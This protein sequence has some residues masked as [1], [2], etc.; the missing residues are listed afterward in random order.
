MI[1]INIYIAIFNYYKKNDRYRLTEK[2]F[3]HYRNIQSS[4]KDS[5]RFT[6]TIQG[7]EGG[8]S[9]ELALKYFD[10]S[11][12]IEYN[13]NGIMANHKDFLKMFND[14]VNTGFKIGTLCNTP[15]ISFW[16]GSNDYISGNF[17]EQVLNHYKRDT[18]QIYGIDKHTNGKN[19]TCLFN[20]TKNKI[21][22]LD[23]NNRNIFW[24]TG[25]EKHSDRSKYKYIGGIIG[26]N[27][28]CYSMYPDIIDKWGFDEGVNE[29]Y[30]LDKNG[31]DALNTQNVIF[32]NP[33][34]NESNDITSYNNLIDMNKESKIDISKLNFE[35][36][37]RMQ[38]EYDNF[39]RL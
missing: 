8:F 19:I 28:K 24:W 12:Y 16:A 34:V 18:P 21:N 37:D 20:Y 2:I 4:F 14:K 15:D 25:N 26:I 39:I 5:I 22:I 1:H 27:K 38:N 3:K 11:C 36:R 6:F 17:F 31:I 7:S 30:I 10:D 35:M 29:K 32:L 33:K 9:R 23:S 13:Q